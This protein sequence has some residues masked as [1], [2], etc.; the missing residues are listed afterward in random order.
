M[1]ILGAGIEATSKSSG[2]VEMTPFQQIIMV[3]TSK[4]APAVE[5]ISIQHNSFLTMLRLGTA[6]EM[7]ISAAQI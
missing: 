4:L 1:S 3:S 2:G 7:T 5:M 6:V